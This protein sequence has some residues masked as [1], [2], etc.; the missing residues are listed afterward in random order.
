VQIPLA[1]KLRAAIAQ[2]SAH[3]LGTI[4]DE[5]LSNIDLK[6]PELIEQEKYIYSV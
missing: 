3:G 2:A 5:L 1:K 4:R 6:F